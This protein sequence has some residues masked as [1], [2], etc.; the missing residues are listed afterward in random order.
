MQVRTCRLM[1]VGAYFVRT[2][3]CVLGRSTCG[4]CSGFGRFH[5]MLLFYCGCAWA[6][7]AVE[8]ML[9]SFL[10]PA[11]SPHLDACLIVLHSYILQ[12]IVRNSAVLLPK[13]QVLF[14]VLTGSSILGD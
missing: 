1:L 2:E 13:E 7:D 4:G 14:S 11:V 12:G 10:G 9:L 3:K 6:A 8:M 5:V